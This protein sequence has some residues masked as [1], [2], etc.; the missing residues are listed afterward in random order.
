MAYLFRKKTK[1]FKDYPPIFY[2]N[3]YIFKLKEPFYGVTVL[4][5]ETFIDIP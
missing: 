5:A 3:P 1:E 2:A 4:Y